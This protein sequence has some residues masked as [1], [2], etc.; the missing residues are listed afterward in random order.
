MNWEL[1][2]MVMYLITQD[3]DSAKKTVVPMGTVHEIGIDE[4]SLSDFVGDLIIQAVGK[5]ASLSPNAKSKAFVFTDDENGESHQKIC[6]NL[7]TA[8]S[9]DSFKE[10]ADKVAENYINTPKARD[11]VLFVINCNAEQNKT[12]TPNVLI[13]K[14]DHSSGIVEDF[15][16]HEKISYSEG[17]LSKE[18]TKVIQYPFFDGGNFRYNKVKVYQKQTSDYFQKTFSL[19]LLPDSFQIID[20]CLLAEL[21]EKCPEVFEKYF[22]LPEGDRQQKRELFGPSRIVTDD[23]L[24]DV[25]NTSHLSLK[26][27]M[28]VVDKG[29]DPVRLKISIDDGLKFNGSVDQLNRTYFFAQEGLERYLIVKGVK[30]ETK[31]HFQTVEFMKLENLEDTMKRIKFIPAEEVE[32]SEEDQLE[33]DDA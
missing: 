33:E 8:V 3:E 17:I 21:Q 25:D 23:D 5:K 16:E 10:Q 19:G 1:V 9:R 32:E 14:S 24:L 11:G 6:D 15:E 26:T 20:A 13:I 2:Y 7:L 27:Q 29:I 18:L 4:E 31:D 22:E 30:F 12:L 28:S